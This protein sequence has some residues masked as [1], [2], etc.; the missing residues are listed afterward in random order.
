MCRGLHVHPLF[1]RP[2]DG[3]VTDETLS[4]RIPT[5]TLHPDAYGAV[6]YPMVVCAIQ[7]AETKAMPLDNRWTAVGQALASMLLL[8]S[9]LWLPWAT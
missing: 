5:V 9:G 6:G 2:R 7:T 3:P 4:R 8:A 1:T